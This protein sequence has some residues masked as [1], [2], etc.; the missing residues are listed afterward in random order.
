M[1]A[2][3]YLPQTEAILKKTVETHKALELNT[4]GAKPDGSGF[5]PEAPL[6]DLYLSLGGTR[7][8]LGSDAHTPETVAAGL[9]A[10]RKLLL[11]KGV[12]EALYYLDRKA[13]SYQL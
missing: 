5:H 12:T 11:Q 9:E 10:G 4:Q 2:D 13:I 7:F 1:N 8:C 3:R 6:I